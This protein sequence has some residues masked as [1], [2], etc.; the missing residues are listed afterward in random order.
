MKCGPLG[1]RECDRQGLPPIHR[2]FCTVEWDFDGL[3]AK[4]YLTQAAVLPSFFW[5]GADDPAP[6]KGIQCL[7]ACLSFVFR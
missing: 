4:I 1:R 6:V 3:T 7:T 5:P 2:E